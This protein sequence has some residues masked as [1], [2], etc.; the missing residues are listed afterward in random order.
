MALIY[1]E[2]KNVVP[3]S[4]KLAIALIISAFLTY[5][6]LIHLKM[7]VFKGNFYQF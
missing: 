5:A 3:Y 4:V 1:F 6:E 2:L 7:L